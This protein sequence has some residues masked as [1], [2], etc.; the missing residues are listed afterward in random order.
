MTTGDIEQVMPR[1][2][3]WL[4]RKS[5]SPETRLPALAQY[6]SLKRHTLR[7]IF[8]VIALM[9]F[10]FIY[11]FFFSVLVPYY[12]AF[13]AMPVIFVMLLAIWALPDVNSAP[14]K[15]LSWFFYAFF[16]VLICWP[17]YLAIALPG[18]PWITLIR[19]TSFPM[20]LLLLIC[21]SISPR[22]R[23]DTGRSLRAVSAIP[24]LWCIFILI[25]LVSIGES[26]NISASV[27]KFI[28]AQTTWTAA[29]F[30]AAY[31]F[32][33]PGQIKRWSLILWAMA[34]FV[35]IIAIWE[36]R[37]SRLPWAG[38]IP[39]FL[40]I[41][42]DAVQEILG[43]HMRAYT[44]IYRAEAT[45]STPLGLAEYL[46]LTLP[47]VLHFCTPRWPAKLRLA[48]CASIPLIIYA[49]FLS[50]SKLGMVGA[51]AATSVYCLM[52]AFRH[53]RRNKASLIAAATFFFYPAAIGV[54]GLMMAAS[55]RFYITIMGDASHTAS[56]QARIEQMHVGIAKI[57]KWPFGYG[58]GQAAVTITNVSDY[59]TID[60]YFLSVAIEYGVLGFITYYGI[61]AIAMYEGSRRYL[62]DR[63]GNEDQS[64]LLPITASFVAF[65]V[66]KFVFSQQDNHPVVFMMLGALLGLIAARRTQTQS[67]RGPDRQ[68]PVARRIRHQ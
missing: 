31:L 36:H 48:A 13:L 60:S 7:R 2:R 37:I 67:Y 5:A 62:T 21:C 65:M 61:F 18:L 40:K 9:L 58:I 55:H 11:G 63:T 41:N 30:A 34:I 39:S 29:F 17:N 51:L 52:A 64:F 57:L 23:A 42:D 32:S 22:F 45:F 19:L 38:H 59:I 50:G 27:Q 1:W 15:Q 14:T 33:R 53:W 16:I 20:A 46:A 56:T 68:R 35:S 3:T 10:C 12:I 8:G 6:H 26:K 54:V 66:A 4:S 49:D 25:Q 47:F 43:A 24:T 44:N 28:V